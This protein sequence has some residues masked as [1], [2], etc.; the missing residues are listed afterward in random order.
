LHDRIMSFP[1]GKFLKAER[2]T[3]PFA[4]IIYYTLQVTARSS[5]SEVFASLGWSLPSRSELR[6]G[7]DLSS[8]CCCSGEKQRVSLARTMLKAP[9]ILVLDEVS[10]SLMTI[11]EYMLKLPARPLTRRLHR[12]SFRLWLIDNVPMI[13]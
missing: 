4:E 1:D 3:V 12:K 5:A 2:A 6:R 8:S 7:S 10:L 9:A 11:P 13:C